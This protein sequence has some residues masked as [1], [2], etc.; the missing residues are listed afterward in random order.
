[1]E[2]IPT[3]SIGNVLIIQPF[4]PLCEE[5]HETKLE[6]LEKARITALEMAKKENETPKESAEDA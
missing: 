2:R 3:Q 6:S 5:K 1:M 4:T